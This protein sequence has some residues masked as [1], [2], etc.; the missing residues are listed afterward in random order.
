M[1]NTNW[2][3]LI[4]ELLWWFLI[5]IMYYI[6]SDRSFIGNLDNNYQKSIQ[7]I[8]IL[9]VLFW[10]LQFQWIS[11]LRSEIEWYV[12][13]SGKW[14]CIRLFQNMVVKP[15]K[16][17][18]WSLDNIIRSKT[19]HKKINLSHDKWQWNA[20]SNDHCSVAFWYI[21]PSRDEILWFKFPCFFYSIHSL[22][23]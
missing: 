20:L 16:L 6:H 5:L 18:I 2:I 12:R 21:N 22:D 4:L 11:S 19:T 1:L 9:H 3:N 8:V 15:C 23:V 10:F 7:L 14:K 17:F 13:N